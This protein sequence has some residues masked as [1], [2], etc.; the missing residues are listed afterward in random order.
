MN[1][2]L[3]DEVDPVALC[4]ENI[5]IVVVAGSNAT[6]NWETPPFYDNSGFVSVVSS[7]KPGDI[8]S[9]GIT[10]VT[11]EAN[12]LSGN[13]GSCSFNVSVEGM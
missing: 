2:S 6:V 8:L 10:L 7:H 13:K 5:S 1:D 11:Y 3:T 4:P 9:P 12:D